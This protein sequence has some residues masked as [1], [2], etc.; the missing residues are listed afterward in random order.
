M[1]TL[2]PKL[3]SRIHG[4]N[5]V[6]GTVGSG[7]TLV[8]KVKT[9]IL[10]GGICHFPNVCRGVQTAIIQTEPSVQLQTGQGTS[11]RNT[12]STQDY[13]AY[14]TVTQFHTPTCIYYIHILVPFAEGDY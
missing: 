3:D 13:T 6:Y 10:V 12:R 1:T 4:V 7:E 14:V 2:L 5:I 8:A 11:T 9:V